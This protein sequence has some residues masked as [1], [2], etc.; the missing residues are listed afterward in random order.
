MATSDI[1]KG[2]LYVDSTNNSVGIGT[3][4]NNQSSST[5]SVTLNAA[6]GMS[7]YEL[8]NA[9]VFSGYVGNTGTNMYLVNAKNGSLGLYTNNT[10]RMH[11][12]ST[13]N[14]GIGSQTPSFRL[15]V[16]DGTGATRI[17]VRNT[18]NAAPGSGIYFEVL[19][20]ASVV[21]N[22][23][24]ATQ[25][26]GDMA[27][28][29][30]TSSGAERLRI[31]S[32]GRVT[33]PNHPAFSVYHTVAVPSNSYVVHNSVL[34]NN[35][36]YFNTSNGRFTAPVAGSYMFYATGLVQP[37]GGTSRMR[38][39]KNQSASPVATAE[40]RHQGGTAGA[41]LFATIQAVVTMS[42]NDYIQQYYINDDGS[43]TMY[44]DGTPYVTFG[45]HLIG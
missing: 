8:R 14:V 42:A 13:G 29:T 17:N 35:G 28:F 43:T 37:T 20:G 10:E 16:E 26:N 12:T 30:G 21:G 27:F 41:Y 39:Y 31:D 24:I 6:S 45:G 34:L 36:N 9:D 19:N 2:P 23:T 18:A 32:S 25:S 1:K 38:L 33:M 40:S 11:L 3:T 15:A 4:T 5:T 22:G 7:A 44:S